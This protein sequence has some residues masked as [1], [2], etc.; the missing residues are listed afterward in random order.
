MPP[1][2]K[3]RRPLH[4]YIIHLAWIALTLYQALNAG[5]P[6]RDIWG[7]LFILGVALMVRMV[8]KPNVMELK[9]ETLIVL[10]D[11]FGS[12]NIHI[13]DI[14]RIE[15]KAGPLSSSRIVLKGDKRHVK[16]DY[17]KVRNA[18]FDALKESLNVPVR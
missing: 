14:D 11:F 3:V 8:L 18:D 13:G 1:T 9:G 7:M 12:I 5:L 4:S 6:A 15:I 16:F 10:C 2:I 17:Y